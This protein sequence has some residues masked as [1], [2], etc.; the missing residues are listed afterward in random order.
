M[1]SRATTPV[2]DEEARRRATQSQNLTDEDLQ[3]EIPPV[4]EQVRLR[5]YAIYL[6][7]GGQHGSELDDWLQAEREIRGEP[8][9]SG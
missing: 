6:E 3:I 5:A 7:R 4:D 1:A 2:A 9:I 8:G